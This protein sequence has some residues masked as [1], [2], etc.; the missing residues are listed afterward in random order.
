MILINKLLKLEN[1]NHLLEY[2]ESCWD[3]SST[4]ARSDLDKTSQASGLIKYI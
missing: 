1:K 3:L 2:G 4:E